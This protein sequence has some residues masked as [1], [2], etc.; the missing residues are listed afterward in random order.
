MFK[1]AICF[2][3]KGEMKKIIAAKSLEIHEESVSNQ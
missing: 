2:Q 3:E 1:N